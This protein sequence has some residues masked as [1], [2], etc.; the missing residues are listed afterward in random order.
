MRPD[1]VTDELRDGDPVFLGGGPDLLEEVVTEP[2]EE[3]GVLGAAGGTASPGVDWRGGAAYRH[4]VSVRTESTEVK[5]FERTAC[6]ITARQSVC[7]GTDVHRAG[8]GG[9]T[10]RG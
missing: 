8:V 6:V 9:A 7:T 4:A 2:E 5:R 10:A 1:G 3:A